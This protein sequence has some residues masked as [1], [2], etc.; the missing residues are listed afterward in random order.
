MTSPLCA[1]LGFGNNQFVVTL[2]LLLS[3]LLPGR[4]VPTEVFLRSQTDHLFHGWCSSGYISK[5]QALKKTHTH[6][7]NIIITFKN[8]LSIIKYSLSIYISSFVSNVGLFKSAFKYELYSLFRLMYPLPPPHL[9]LLNLFVKAAIH[10]S[11]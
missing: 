3:R 4:A 9:F 8:S 6:T 1:A 5:R 2:A 11:L 7:H 10:L